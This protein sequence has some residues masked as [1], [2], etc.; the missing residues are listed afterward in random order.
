[1]RRDPQHADAHNFLGH[2]LERRGDLAA[3]RALYERALAINP[4]YPAAHYNLGALLGRAGDAAEAEREYREALVCDHDFAKAHYSLG[5]LL[6][7]RG[8]AQNAEWEY[9]E[10]LRCDPHH[11]GALSSLAALLAAGGDPRA[12]EAAYDAA[13][14]A[15]GDFDHAEA[16]YRD[17]LRPEEWEGERVGA[18]EA[19]HDTEERE[20]DDL[21]GLRN[22]LVDD[23]D[24]LGEFTAKGDG[25]S[26]SSA[27]TPPSQ[28]STRGRAA[29]AQLPQSAAT[30]ALSTAYYWGEGPL[31]GGAGPPPSPP[32]DTG[33]AVRAARHASAGDGETLR[34]ALVQRR[35]ARGSST[36]VASSTAADSGAVGALPPPLPRNDAPPH[37]AP[38]DLLS[39]IPQQSARPSHG[40]AHQQHLTDAPRDATT[41]AR[42]TSRGVRREPGLHHDAELGRHAESINVATP[43]D[44]V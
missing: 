4:D 5:A 36:F 16:A 11:A 31:D 6:Q 29:Q 10:T 39:L 41:W 38:T 8:D 12:A 13:E 15:F 2:L 3:A 25:R 24:G 27:T 34:D 28:Y 9:R 43:L 42:P 35:R 30:T 40:G 33:A 37:A 32:P 17:A 44:T 19:A 7:R 22:A 21:R 14:A 23:E 1:M 26:D 20:D 18:A